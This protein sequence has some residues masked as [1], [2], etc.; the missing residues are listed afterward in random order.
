MTFWGL[1]PPDII[2]KAR[3]TCLSSG[4][5]W[6]PSACPKQSIEFKESAPTEAGANIAN[7]RP[8]K[9][10]ELEFKE[11]A[12]GFPSCTLQAAAGYRASAP[13]E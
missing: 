11:L 8:Q 9:V 4:D 2:Y 13:V 12:H 5:L 3:K 10:V 7:A 6:S 1:I